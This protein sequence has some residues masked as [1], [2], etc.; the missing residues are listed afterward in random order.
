MFG[1]DISMKL[2]IWLKEGK[3]RFCYSLRNMLPIYGSLAIE[4]SPYL[5]SKSAQMWVS[6][7]IIRTFSS[8]RWGFIV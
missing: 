7:K 3:A 5:T 4:L 8:E 6:R 1:K 2:Y